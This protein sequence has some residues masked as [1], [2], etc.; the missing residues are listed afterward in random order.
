MN[1]RNAIVT[2][3]GVLAT[4]ALLV[5]PRRPAFA[6]AVGATLSAGPYKTKTLMAG[7]FSKET[8]QM[9]MSQATHP[10]VQEFAQFENAEQTTIAQALTDMNNP[11]PAPLDAQH[12]AMLKQL[13]AQ[14]GKAFDMAYVQGQITGHQEL[15]VIQQSY[16]NAAPTNADYKHIAMLART[17]IQMH[18]AMLTDLQN[19]LNA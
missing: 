7:T 3:S 1:R 14:S 13:Q 2:L 9:A 4:S 11:P 15:L 12:A 6:Q 17:V 5:A 10:K 19:T 16:L 8:S 18:L